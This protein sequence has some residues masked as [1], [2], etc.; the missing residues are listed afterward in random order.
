MKEKKFRLPTGWV[1]KPYRG[2]VWLLNILSALLALNQV[3]VAVVIQYVIDS[4][5]AGKNFT[6]W[7]WSLAAVLLL[8]VLLQMASSWLAGS[9]TDN[10]TASLRRDLLS[11]AAR[12]EEGGL[13]SYHS[14]E[15]MNRGMEDVK[16]L[17]DGMVSV[18]PAV[19][20]HITRLIGAIAVIF[21]LYSGLIPILIVAGVLMGGASACLRPIMRRQ[22][23][24]VRQTEDGVLS[25]LQE[26]LQQLELIQS[27][28]LKDTVLRRFQKRQK[29]NLRAKRNRRFWQVGIHSV[30]SLVS[31]IS[32]GVL[33]IWGAA[34]VAGGGMSYGTLIA[35]TQLLAIFRSPI[36]GLS[37]TISQFAAVEVAYIRLQELLNL[38]EN[39][40][41]TG[42][43]SVKVESVVFENVTFCYPDEEVPVVENYSAQLPI[44]SWCCLT[45]ASGRGKSTLFRLMLGIYQPQTGRVYLKTD[46]G[47]MVCSESTRSLFAY[48]PQ[49]Y[50]LFS[51]TIR[52]NL[53][54]VK[55]NAT[56]EELY[57]AIRVAGAEYVDTLTDKLDT[58]MYE[59]NSGLSKGQIQRLAIARAVLMNRPILL[60][61]EC[62]SALDKETETQVLTRL[63]SLNTQAIVVTHR[64]KVLKEFSD[65][66]F[67]NL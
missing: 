15:L 43:P 1:Y 14:G 66:T 42:L 6:F 37:G 31:Q 59:H 4:A 13:Q 33:L 5:I 46:K 9:T 16:T 18:L 25:N 47:E 23:N 65:V 49:D 48:V 17:C 53:M 24:Y 56:E 36:V 28:Q 55:P 34:Q 26:N 60:L 39:K 2:R 58:L 32:T 38:G 11:A 45:G 27:L 62:T 21:A 40:A 63:K 19:V 41:L 12:C 67:V 50:A 35:M 51:G 30:I 29:T 7:A 44:S 54:L 20:G 22:H 3:A 61:D 64:P 8:W 10:C 52:E 57:R